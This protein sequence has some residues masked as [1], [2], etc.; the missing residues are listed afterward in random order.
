MKQK[1][2]NLKPV[3]TNFSG[4][5]ILMQPKMKTGYQYTKKLLHT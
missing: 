4:G 5:K 2:K 3:N 1:G